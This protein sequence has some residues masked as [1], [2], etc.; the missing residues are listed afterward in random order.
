MKTHAYGNFCF[1]I[2]LSHDF[3]NNNILF[4]YY[5]KKLSLTFKYAL[6]GK[7]MGNLVIDTDKYCRRR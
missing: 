7:V 5:K 2:R 3:N 6:Y 1:N 4:K